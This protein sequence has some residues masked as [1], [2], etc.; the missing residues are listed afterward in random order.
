MAT[1]VALYGIHPI[2]ELLRARRRPLI[3][4]Y[5]TEQRPKAW[6]QIAAHLPAT[7]DVRAVSKE[8]LTKLAGTPD[9]QNVVALTKELPLRKALFNPAKS[10]YLLLIDGIQDVRNLGAILRS[11]YCAGV[12]GVIITSERSA[13]F[14]GAALKASAGLAEHLDIMIAQNANTVADQLIKAGYQLYVAALGGEPLPTITFSKTL[15]IVIGSEGLGVSPQLQSKGTLLM[16][17]QSEPT[18]SYNASVAA[19]IVLYTA[20]I[21]TGALSAK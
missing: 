10:P 15:C 17:P 11:A 16:I 9:H 12:S 6:K 7:A 20:G 21:Q 5:T 18:I 1:P 13:P 19:G 8:H 3:V 4:L 14:H 2:V